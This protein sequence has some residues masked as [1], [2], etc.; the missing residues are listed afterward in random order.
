MYIWEPRLRH[1]KDTDQRLLF[2]I[3]HAIFHCKNNLR[4][5]Y[6]HLVLI[7]EDIQAQRGETW[8]VLSHVANKVCKCSMEGYGILYFLFSPGIF[9]IHILNLVPHGT[10][11]DL[12]SPFLL[13][14]PEF[15]FSLW[16]FRPLDLIR[17]NWVSLRWKP[18]RKET[19]F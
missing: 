13:E 9:L 4:I 8:L 2:H 12:S 15:T 7:G 11:F 3:L 5:G 6:Y 18:H 14:S 10:T 16:S 19:Y 17:E 1:M